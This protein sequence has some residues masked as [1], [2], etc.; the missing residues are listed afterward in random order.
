MRLSFWGPRDLDLLLLR[1]MTRMHPGLDRIGICTWCEVHVTKPCDAF[2]TRVGGRDAGALP[3]YH[4][5]K[6]DIKV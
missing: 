3:H 4:R 5:K 2:H 1:T 6:G